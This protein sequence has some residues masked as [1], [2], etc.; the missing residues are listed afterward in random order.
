V[1]AYDYDD[2]MGGLLHVQPLAVLSELFSGDAEDRRASLHMIRD[3]IR[4]GKHPLSTVSDDIIIGWC[5]NEPAVRYP[6]ATGAVL[7]FA[8]PN[9]KEPYDWMPIV[10]RLLQ[11]SPNPLAVLEVIVDRLRVNSWSGSRALKMEARLELLRCLD[12]GNDHAL[13][14][15]LIA[16]TKALAASIER[17]RGVEAEND[18]MRARRFE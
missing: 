15:L 17:E 10:R 16:T 5:E 8:R 2:L 4:L 12:V 7:L 18:R 14:E 1:Q 9:E 3:M 6:L 11:S 13:L